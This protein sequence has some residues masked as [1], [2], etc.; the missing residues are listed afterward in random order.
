MTDQ[1]VL[2]PEYAIEPACIERLRDAQFLL[3][4][5]G[6][7]GSKTL[8]EYPHNWLLE[9]HKNCKASCQTIELKRVVELLSR[10][11]FVRRGNANYDGKRKW[12][13]NALLEHK[14]KPFRAI[15]SRNGLGDLR[16]RDYRHVLPL[17]LL[18]EHPLWK[19]PRSTSVNRESESMCRAI[20][21]LLNRSWELVFVDPHFAPEERI[22]WCRPIGAFIQEAVKGGR[23]LKRCELHLSSTAAYEHFRRSCL[24]NLAREVPR[25][26]QLHVYR[27]K[28]KE[29]EGERFHPRY[30]LTDIGGVLIEG[31]L[32]QAKREGQ[33]TDVCLLDEKHWR[34]RWKQYVQDRSGGSA[35]FVKKSGDGEYPIKIA[36]TRP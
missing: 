14:I 29:Q 35:A 31:G 16:S 32:D 5:A 10:A 17:D 26:V 23:T 25:D 6:P 13:E 12:I 24:Q 27:W 22:L 9:V 19:S 3:H 4:D 18:H 20:A 1:E 34:R 7:F 36:G 8:A 28:M 30:I 21:P 15:V 33:T 11:M 2:F